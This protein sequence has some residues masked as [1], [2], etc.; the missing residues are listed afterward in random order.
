MAGLLA[1]EL[2]YS[3]GNWRNLY[4]PVSDYTKQYKNKA[5]LLS[6]QPTIGEQ[7]D[8]RVKRQETAQAEVRAQAEA[9]AQ[10][11]LQAKKQAEAQAQ[12]QAQAKAQAEKQAKAQAKAYEKTVVDSQGNRG[13]TGQGS[14]S[15]A[16]NRT[17]VYNTQGSGSRGGSSRNYGVTGRRVTGGR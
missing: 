3:E 17:S 15:R 2:D 11:D 4:M 5:S 12:I 9:K 1:G 8:R 6:S 10:A 7:R 16:G 13:Y 14:Q